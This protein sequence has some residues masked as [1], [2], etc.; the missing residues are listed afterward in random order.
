MSDFDDPEC[1]LDYISETNKQPQIRWISPKLKSLLST[2]Q[3]IWF[4]SSFLVM[5]FCQCIPMKSNWNTE[6]G[7]D[8]G[9]V[10]EQTESARLCVLKEPL[11][12]SVIGRIPQQMK[13]H[14]VGVAG[15]KWGKWLGKCPAKSYARAIDRVGQTDSENH[16]G[17]LK[18]VLLTWC[19][20]LGNLVSRPD[21]NDLESKWSVMES[22]ATRLRPALAAQY[23]GKKKKKHYKGVAPPSTLFYF[24]STQTKFTLNAHVFTKKKQSSCMWVNRQN[25]ETFPSVPV[26]LKGLQMKSWAGA[27]QALFSLLWNPLHWVIR[28]KRKFSTTWTKKQNSCHHLLLNRT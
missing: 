7:L 13:R 4:P 11:W 12:G 3:I 18:C 23:V 2:Q 25:V 14:Q 5:L 26:A 24:T 9:A 8:P 22:G 15:R 1:F 10:S 21:T 17:R 27:P 20:H 28:L 16:L 6:P 19:S